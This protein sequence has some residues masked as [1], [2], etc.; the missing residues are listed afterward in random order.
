MFLTKLGMGLFVGVCVTTACTHPSND[1]LEIAETVSAF[2][3]AS[4]ITESG[5]TIT[6]VTGGGKVLFQDAGQKVCWNG[7][8]VAGAT[9]AV[10][11]YA[12]GES[13]G[14]QLQLSRGSSVTSQ[15][16]I[17]A[18]IVTTNA[19]SAGWEPVHMKDK[20]VSF[21][22]LSGTATVC[23]RAKTNTASWV[24]SVEK[25]T[26]TGATGGGGGS[27][28]VTLEAENGTVTGAVNQP[29]HVL[30]Q[31]SGQKVCW[32]GV[33]VAGVTGYEVRYGQSEPETE[34]FRLSFGTTAQSTVSLPMNGNWTT[35]TGVANGTATGSGTQTVCLESL[36]DLPA[37]GWVAS[38]DKVVLKG[39]GGTTT[40]PPTGTPAPG[41]VLW[42]DEFD[43]TCMLGGT[44]DQNGLCKN[45]WYYNHEAQFNNEWQEY[46]TESEALTHGV[47]KRVG[48]VL[49]INAKNIN[50]KWWSARVITKDKYEFKQGRLEAR[51][52]LPT[53]PNPERQGPWP[54]FWMLGHDI[55]EQPAPGGSG[56]MRAGA[57]EIDIFEAVVNQGAHRIDANIIADENCAQPRS[58]PCQ[59]PWPTRVAW[60]GWPKA[61]P[62][63]NFTNWHNYAVEWTPTRL[64]FYQ[65][66]VSFGSVDP[67]SQGAGPVFQQNMYILFNLAIGG[68]LGGDATGLPN[69]TMEVDW[70]RHTAL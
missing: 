8:N 15:T 11:R 10:V 13:D 14:D 47:V 21:A 62:V 64:Q 70:I 2:T 45:H 37:G 46:V 53:W 68:V 23:V 56:W 66:G 39:S 38:I 33:N 36:S 34:S 51:L 9:G 1:E 61:A 31:A 43:G 63:T 58:A 52:R 29:P 55:N 3:S 69:Q 32:S 59:Y 5:S 50:G 25:V 26:L 20:A 41:T 42:K 44:L 57:E 17:G 27:T 6:G 54:A 48:G 22:A 30:F 49:Q 28:L 16:D 18:A 24:A 65:D 19:P 4:L 7:V 67:T 12:T 40:P 35:Y 60:N